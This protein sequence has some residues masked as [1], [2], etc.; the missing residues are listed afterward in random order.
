VVHS[1]IFFRRAYL[2]HAPQRGGRT[3][4][5]QLQKDLR[6][7]PRPRAGAESARLSQVASGVD[8]LRL[9]L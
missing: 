9:N 5:N 1:A 7:R 4:S 3:P 6:R 2:P 8:S